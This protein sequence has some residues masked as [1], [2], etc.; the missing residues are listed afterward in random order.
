MKLN[1]S[2]AGVYIISATPFNDSSQID[3]DSAD[4]L[5]EFYLEHGVHG[6]T[7]LGMMGEAPKLSSDESHA[8]M[9]HMLERV[10]QRVPVIVGVSNAGLSNIASLSHAA[11]DQGAA[12]VMIAPP[13]G[14]N[15]D[16]KLRGYFAQCFE[17]LGEQVP[18]CYQD[19][20]LSTG[21]HLSASLFLQLVEDF[22]QLVM[23]KHEDWPGLNKLTKI[24]NAAGRRV[25][26]PVSYTHLRA[27]ET[28]EH[29]VCRLLL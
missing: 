6:M 23:L 27:H 24:R 5:V 19:F 12:G 17:A 13:G 29:L 7:I 1:E 15:T 28:P 20:P 26:I 18:V 16:E 9:T 4:R 2:A 3:Y 22:R 14:L 8:F 25:S 11:M 10:A 21:V